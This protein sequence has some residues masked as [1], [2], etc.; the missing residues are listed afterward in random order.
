MS[1]ASPVPG[2]THSPRVDYFY[3]EAIGNFHYGEGHPMR[4]HRVRLTHHLV[5]NYGLYKHMNIFRP[6]PASRAD[7]TA[8]HSDD[9]IR[10]LSD[11]TPDSLADLNPGIIERYNMGEDCPVFDGLYEYCCTYTG[12]SLAGAARLNQ[13][14]ADIVINWAGGLH[15]AKKSEVHNAYLPGTHWVPNGYLLGT[16]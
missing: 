11:V 10:F 7:L 14:C 5:V 2:D 1:S 4:P 16:H 12:G 13:G 6:R 9:Y 15:H 3:D 8:F